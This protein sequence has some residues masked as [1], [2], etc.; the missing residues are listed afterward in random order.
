MERYTRMGVHAASCTPA[1]FSENGRKLRDLPPVGPGR[2]HSLDRLSP[3]SN[4]FVFIAAKPV[5]MPSRIACSDHARASVDSPA[6]PDPH[7]S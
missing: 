3:A 6:T 4:S 1:A 5:A 7:E 2:E